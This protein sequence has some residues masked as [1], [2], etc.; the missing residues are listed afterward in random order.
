MG[1]PFK[2]LRDIFSSKKKREKNTDTTST[3]QKKTRPTQPCPEPRGTAATQAIINGY[4]WALDDLRSEQSYEDWRARSSET[5]VAERKPYSIQPCAFPETKKWVSASYA[6]E[7]LELI[8]AMRDRAA[9]VKSSGELVRFGH[10]VVH[11]PDAPKI[12]RFKKIEDGFVPFSRLVKG[13]VA[14]TSPTASDDGRSEVGSLGHASEDDRNRGEEEVEEPYPRPS[15]RL[16]FYGPSYSNAEDADLSEA[17]T[18]SDDADDSDSY[19]LNAKVNVA[20]RIRIVRKAHQVELNARQQPDISSDDEVS[21]DFYTS[22]EELHLAEPI[23]IIS[24]AREIEVK[25]KSR[26]QTHRYRSSAPR[27]VP[28]DRDRVRRVRV[29]ERGPGVPRLGDSLELSRRVPSPPVPKRGKHHYTTPEAQLRLSYIKSYLCLPP[30]MTTARLLL[31]LLVHHR[32][33]ATAAA[34][35][36][37]LLLRAADELDFFGILGTDELPRPPPGKP[38]DM[39]NEDKA[40]YWNYRLMKMWFKMKNSLFMDLDPEEQRRMRD[41]YKKMRA[42]TSFEQEAKGWMAVEG[43]VFAVA[44]EKREAARESAV[45]KGWTS[46]KPRRLSWTGPGPSYLSVVNSVDDE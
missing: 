1:F 21:D 30:E 33:S 34:R 25:P 17:E 39:S 5:P 15:A 22:D 37:P 26:Q 45:L 8:L 18:D 24:N 36:N 32:D 10:A 31:H 40:I 11:E 20:R 41:K 38:R 6:D 12:P 14:L 28:R 16:R 29:R 7:S 35:S 13:G 19:S 3:K 4:D 42:R 23:E 9:E 44:Y 27:P 43:R 46:K 2:S